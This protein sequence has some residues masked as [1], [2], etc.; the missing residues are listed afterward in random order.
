[1]RLVPQPGGADDVLELRVFRFPAELAHGFFGRGDQA[2]GVAG[3]AG[4]FDGLDLLAG[5]FFAGLDHFADRITLAV[6]E[7]VKSLLARFDRDDV[8]LGEVRSEEHTS[9]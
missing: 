2:R 8:R 5:D 6:A 4:A 3:A 7:V 1:M 9:E